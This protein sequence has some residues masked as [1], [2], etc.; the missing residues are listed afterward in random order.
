MHKYTLLIWKDPLTRTHSNLQHASNPK[1]R[2]HSEW[3]HPPMNPRALDAQ[4]NAQVDAGPP[5][6]CQPTVTTAGVARDALHTLQGALS[7][8]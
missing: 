1:E 2:S 7:F 6:V 3:A 5:W 8:Q 4:G